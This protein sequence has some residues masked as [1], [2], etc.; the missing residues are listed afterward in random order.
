MF[1]NVVDAKDRRATRRG[2][3][4]RRDSADHPLIDSGPEDRREQA[5]AR[6]A[7]EQRQSRNP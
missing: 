6:H 2:N 5:F 7:D 4:V 3:D 1:G